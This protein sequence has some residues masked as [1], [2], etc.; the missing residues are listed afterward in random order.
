M[1]ANCFYLMSLFLCI[2]SM[3]FAQ[4]EKDLPRSTIIIPPKQVVVI[5]YPLLKGYTIKLWNESN[6]DVEV[7]A[8]NQET[9]SIYKSISVAKNKQ[10]R[11]NI[12]HDQ[13]L[14]LENRFFASL[15]IEYIIF[16]GP[17]G[18][19][20]KT[21]SARTAGF[22]LVN[23]TRQTLPIHIP[24]IM[25]PRLSPFTNTGVELPLGQKIFLK[26]PQENLLIL[27]VTDTIQKGARIDVAD[28][29][30]AALNREDDEE[31][32]LEN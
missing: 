31:K 32:E 5:N 13:Y 12:D 22:Y 30:D 7:S 10:T 9:D 24:G 18:K 19:G 6:F 20:N 15:K 14:Q 16:K 4:K 17:P 3:M 1:K 26:T 8:R 21:T 27:T 29:I 23:T 28:L 11:F 2:T 25:S